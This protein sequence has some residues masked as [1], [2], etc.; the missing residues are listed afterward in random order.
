M[1]SFK[2]NIISKI[3]LITG[4]RYSH[5]E[6]LLDQMEKKNPNDEA[7]KQF[8]KMMNEINFK[9]THLEKKTRGFFGGF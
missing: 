6:N 7:L 4:K 3:R 2:R 8:S 9:I 5:L 1:T